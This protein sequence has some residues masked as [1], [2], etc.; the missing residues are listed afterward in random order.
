M[1]FLLVVNPATALAVETAL[2][3]LAAKKL[4]AEVRIDAS[5]PRAELLASI[6][7]IACT[8]RRLLVWLDGAEFED[9]DSMADLL[10][11][12]YETLSEAAG[13]Q[14]LSIE[15]ACVLP[16]FH[17]GSVPVCH[18]RGPR[19]KHVVLGGT[20][21]RLHG[22]HKVLLTVAASLATV[23][24]ALGVSGAPLL[25]EKKGGAALEPW[26]QRAQA[27]VEFLAMVRPDLPVH[28]RELLDP[29]GPALLPEMEVLVV[30]AETSAGG[31]SVNQRRCELGLAPLQVFIAP[32]VLEAGG[33]GAKVS[34]TRSRNEAACAAAVGDCWDAVASELDAPPDVAARWAG[35]LRAL[36]SSGAG[37]S[38]QQAALGD[39]AR[40]LRSCGAGY[41]EAALIENG[42]AQCIAIALPGLKAAADVH[43]AVQ[44]A[45]GTP[46]SEYGSALL[47]LLTTDLRLPPNVQRLTAALLSELLSEQESQESLPALPRA[48]L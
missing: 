39:V 43:T 3:K 16:N 23:G 15:D 40:Q 14:G 11:Q 46:L 29:F 36:A 9:V 30:S 37:A 5:Q 7:G 47:A 28:I 10:R 32:L 45:D 26:G 38:H 42:L 25:V 19:F 6:R 22:G 34:S 1:V 8:A 2:V 12:C 35:V 18:L 27:A 44:A 4:S 31:Q 24:L 17:T 48:R 13:S 33:A 20:F 21:D 41:G